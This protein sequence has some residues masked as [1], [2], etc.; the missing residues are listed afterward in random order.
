MKEI[1]RVATTPQ[2]LTQQMVTG[3]H[4][5]I[6]VLTPGLLR[7]EYSDDGVF[8]DRATQ[9]VWHRDF[10]PADYRVI[11]TEDGIEIHTE[12]LQLIYNEKEFSA[13]GLSI[14]VKGNLTAYH[15][16]WH[17]GEPI[18]DLGGTARTLDEADGAIPLDHGVASRNGFSVLDDSRSQ[19]LLEDGWI[20]TRKKGVKDLYFF[21]YGH[22]Y[23][24]A[25]ADFYYLCGKTP[26]LPRFA[27]GNWWS[28]YY[29]YTE[30]SYRE[31]MDR[32][33]R[34][35]LPF[36]V[37]VI[38]MDWHLVDIDPKYGSGSP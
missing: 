26:M 31:L 15:S 10:Q 17:Y 20:E 11:H 3:E 2:A 22:N 38:D 37:A 18:T 28:R 27:L 23:K 13:N 14:Q 1:Y 33:E 25:L 29:R 9:M 7:L 12:M 8:E 36:T 4:Y 35:N 32:F 21:G 16:I 19:V 24:Q 5:R 34:E 6:T 30:E